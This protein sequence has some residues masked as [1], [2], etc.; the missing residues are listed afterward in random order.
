MS[1]PAIVIKPGLWG[2]RVEVE[3]EPPRA[4]FPLRSFPD[5][6]AAVTHAY[7]LAAMRGWIVRDECQ[8]GGA[9]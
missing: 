7:T 4:E 3:V 2:R 1:G 8:P 9:T 6:A 5:H